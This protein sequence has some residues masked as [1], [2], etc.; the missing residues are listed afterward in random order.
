MD[1]IPA[2]V[3]IETAKTGKLAEKAAAARSALA[4]CALCP[5][6]CRIDRGAGPD[7]ICKTGTRAVVSAVHPHFGEEAPLVGTHGSGTIFFTH[8]NLM[9]NFCQNFDISHQGMGSEVPDDELA[10]MM[11]MLQDRGCHNINLVTPS[12]VIPQILSALEIAAEKGLSLPLVYNSGGYD[13]VGALK[14]LEGVVDIYMPDFK[15]WDSRIA[16][17]TCDAP[18]YP[19]IARAAL[20][21][22]HR[23]AG[24]L[25]VD[26]AGIARRGLLVR[27]LV[28]PENLAGTRD[29]MQ[30]IHDRISPNTYVNVMSQYRPCGKAREVKGLNRMVSVAEYRQAVEMAREAGLGRLDH[31][32]LQ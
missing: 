13:D 28:L 23:Q 29:I 1:A 8:C 12:H 4:R 22:M 24:D 14:V 10:S 30:F 2:P 16:G 25:V 18:D 21:E 5:R 20:V 17:E 9:C 19:D 15:F 7:G 3:Y 11:L 31:F 27:H 32:Q 6:K 26:P